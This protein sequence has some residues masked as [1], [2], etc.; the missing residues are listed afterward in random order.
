MKK[1]ITMLAICLLAI[2]SLTAG[3][4]NFDMASTARAT[5]TTNAFADFNV[6][7]EWCELESIHVSFP[8]VSTSSIAFYAVS[9][10]GLNTWQ[11]G[12]TITKVN[13]NS[14][15]VFESF[16]P[17]KTVELTNQAVLVLSST[18]SVTNSVTSKVLLKYPVIGT[19]KGVIT[20]TGTAEQSF[21]AKVFLTSP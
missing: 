15:N 18:N 4:L 7:L 14:Y 1:V 21:R 6:G 12:D 9:D 16:Y 3:G 11:I 20:K 2:G 10:G 13:T 5:V 8:P 17:R 19:L